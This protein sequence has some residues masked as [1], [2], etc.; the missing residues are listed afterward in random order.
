LQA[1]KLHAELLALLNE[2]EAKVDPVINIFVNT[3]VPK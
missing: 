1:I 2:K 3:G